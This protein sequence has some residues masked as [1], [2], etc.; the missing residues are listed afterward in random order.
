MPAPGSLTV[1]RVAAAGLG[2]GRCGHL[3]SGHPGPCQAG[4]HL[5]EP[6]GFPLL[7]PVPGEEVGTLAQRERKSAVEAASTQR[8]VH[9]VLLPR[10]C[11]VCQSISYSLGPGNSKTATHSCPALSQDRDPVQLSGPHP[12]PPLFLQ[13]LLRMP[14]A[15]GGP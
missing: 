9:S 2:L 15:P 8:P 7:P 6:A 3:T 13:L 12:R 1:G 5:A 10:S 11:F 4:V 14:W